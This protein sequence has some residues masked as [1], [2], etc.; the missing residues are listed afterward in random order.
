LSAKPETM[1]TTSDR[2]PG[3]V[4]G[5]DVTFG[6]GVTLGANV[7]IHDGVVI[8]DECTIGDHAVLGKRP[9]LS[10]RSRARRDPTG[11]L[12]LEAGVSIGA[13][14]IVFAGAIIGKRT[15]IGDQAHVRERASLGEECMIGRGAA[16]GAD[17]TIGARVRL[18][19][20]AWLTSYAVVEEDVFVGPGVITTNDRSMAR[21]SAADLV[22]QGPVLRRACRVGAGVVLVPGVEIGEEAFVG[23]GSM[24]AHDVPR[25]AWVIGN[26]ARTIRQVSDE[27]LLI[28]D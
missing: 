5:E 13:G 6:R 4:V 17:A 25:R 2:A 26:P 15:A 9:I 28:R 11:R 12:V 1:L 8:G 20:N 14:A 19:T 3:L 23:A 18:Q 10:S 24:V 27:E 7:V 22:L 16:V 21:A